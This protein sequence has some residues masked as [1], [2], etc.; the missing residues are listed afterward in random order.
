MQHL[1]DS[2]TPVLYI[3]RTVLEGCYLTNQAGCNGRALEVTATL[4]FVIFVYF[5]GVPRQT[6]QE[7]ISAK[8]HMP[9]AYQFRSS[10]YNICLVLQFACRS[11]NILLNYSAKE[12]YYKAKT[13]IT[14][15]TYDV[16]SYYGQLLLRARKSDRTF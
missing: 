15:Y 8:R 12:T 6:R 13:C 10:H 4:N 9:I 11:P 5:P 16:I 7:Q 14:Q 3:G 1:E 2:G